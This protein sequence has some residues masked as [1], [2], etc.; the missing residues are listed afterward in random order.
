M[1]TEQSLFASFIRRQTLAREMVCFFATCVRD[2]PDRRSM[3]TCFRLTS[4]RER[5]ICRPSSRALL[6]PL[7]TRST[8][9][10][11]SSS[12]IAEMMV[13][14]RRPIG[15]PVATPSLRLTNSI[16]RLSSS[17]TICKKLLVLLAMRSKAAT[18]TTE[19]FFRRASA[20]RASRPGRR[21]F[22]P[23]TPRSSYSCTT[24]KPRCA[25]NS[26]RSYN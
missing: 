17:S 26:R 2:N 9:S 16:P 21:A 23:Q 24:S 10:D 19:N 11:L 15:P 6:I 7:L 1:A 5:P 3:T 18:S 14:K 22:F 12:A 8:T 20:M 4:R 13:T 25:A